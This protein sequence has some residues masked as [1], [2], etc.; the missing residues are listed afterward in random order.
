[1]AYHK[2]L[3]GVGNQVVDAVGS[4]PVFGR[5][6]PGRAWCLDEISASQG[7]AEQG[8]P[9]DFALPPPGL[10]SAMNDEDGSRHTSVPRRGQGHEVATGPQ[11][12]ELRFLVQPSGP[13]P[14]VECFAGARDSIIVPAEKCCHPRSIDAG[15][16]ADPRDRLGGEPAIQRIRQCGVSTLRRESGELTTKI[17]IGGVFR[18]EPP[19]DLLGFG[20]LAE[21]LQR[22]RRDEPLLG[23]RA[24]LDGATP[25]PGHGAR[26]GLT[27]S[28]GIAVNREL[29]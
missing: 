5:R 4:G 10:T 7:L 16:P 26:R 29:A 3:P 23:G 6:W 24:L 9:V 1:M 12:R 21:H 17:D 11:P 13:G 14:F 8:F 27:C 22:P 19:R 18:D 15:G 2:R 28:D 25:I 20:V